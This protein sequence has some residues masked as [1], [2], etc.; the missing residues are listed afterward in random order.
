[1]H[2]GLHAQSNPTMSLPHLG[3]L[4]LR[5]RRNINCHVTSS[6]ILMHDLMNFL[7]CKSFLDFAFAIAFDVFPF[8][9]LKAKY[10]MIAFPNILPRA[11]DS[12]LPGAYPQSD[13][14]SG[15]EAAR[16]VQSHLVSFAQRSPKRTRKV[17][18]ITETQK[19]VRKGRLQGKQRVNT[20]KRPN[21]H[22]Y[23]G[24]KDSHKKK[25]A[26]SFNDVYYL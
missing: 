18:R 25:Y 16:K 26:T 13:E 4:F 9:P 24:K 5:I 2:N 11:L 14:E 21:M 1:M 7:K 17:G 22:G 3:K 15:E 10:L 8:I 6:N 23:K 20:K 19:G 12:G